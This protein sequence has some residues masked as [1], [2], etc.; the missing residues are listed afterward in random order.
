MTVLE[1]LEAV[2]RVGRVECDAGKLRLKFPKSAV[3]GLQTAIEVLRTGRTA[4]LA[5]LSEDG[6]RATGGLSDVEFGIPSAE[7]QARAL[8]RLFQEQG[9]GGQPGKITAETIRHGE[10]KGVQRNG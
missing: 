1:A 4:A 7:W 2:R 9:S 8:N 5:L 3:L 6:P 10:Q